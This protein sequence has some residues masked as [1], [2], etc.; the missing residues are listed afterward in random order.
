MN[1]CV[2]SALRM[3]VCVNVCVRVCSAGQHNAE[4]S[5]YKC[6][7]FLPLPLSY[8]IH[9]PPVAPLRHNGMGRPGGRGREERNNRVS[10]N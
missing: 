10:R 5:L 8:L 7:H 3:N 1:E 4:V 9:L 2:F 6:R